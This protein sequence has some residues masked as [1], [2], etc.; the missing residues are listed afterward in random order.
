MLTDP[1]AIRALAHPARLAILEYLGGVDSATAT[2]CA[3]VTGMSPSATSYHLRELARYGLVSET[4]GTDKRERRWRSSGDFSVGQG[5]GKDVRDA[6]ALLGR[7]V[8]GRAD[9]RAATYLDR[10]EEEPPDWW[11]AA[12]FNEA[13]L[14]MTVDEAQRL[15]EAVRKLLKPYSRKRRDAPAGAREVQVTFRLFPLPERTESQP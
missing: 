1:R 5:G 8:L 13:R 14:S 7:L 2:E 10:A 3:E 6:S 11:D 12:V 15:A 4:P 9:E